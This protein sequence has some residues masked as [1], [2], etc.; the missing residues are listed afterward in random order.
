MLTENVRDVIYRNM[1]RLKTAAPG[2]RFFLR[3]NTISLLVLSAVSVFLAGCERL[4]C[5]FGG[6]T[7]CTEVAE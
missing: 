6:E 2:T 5:T 7:G 1:G 4:L 3:V